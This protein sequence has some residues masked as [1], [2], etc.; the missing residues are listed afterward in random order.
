M[1]VSAEFREGSLDVEFEPSARGGEAA[2]R[3]ATRAER[4]TRQRDGD[5]AGRTSSSAGSPEAIFVPITTRTSAKPARRRGGRHRSDPVAAR[6]LVR[7]VRGGRRGALRQRPTCGV[8][9]VYLDHSRRRS[10]RGNS[11]SG[12]SSRATP[13]ATGG[14]RRDV[15]HARETPRVVQSRRRRD[16]REGPGGGCGRARVRARGGAADGGMRLGAG[17]GR[18][19]KTHGLHRALR[20]KRRRRD[21]GDRGKR[22]DRG[23]RTR[24]ARVGARRGGETGSVAAAARS[25]AATAAGSARTRRRRGG[26]RRVPRRHGRRRRRDLRGIARDRR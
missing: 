26:A 16:V 6:S 21:R 18:A 12:T 14:A 10:R 19:R 22:G 20:G 15:Q 2:A 25:A 4:R 11:R 1:L 5:E 13:C 17:R 9:L 3:E 23:R 24:T 7:G 8:P